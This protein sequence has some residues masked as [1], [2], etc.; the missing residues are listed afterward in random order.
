MAWLHV[1]GVREAAG[2]VDAVEVGRAEAQRARSRM[3]LADRRSPPWPG[4]GGRRPAGERDPRS[5]STRSRRR[6]RRSAPRRSS[7]RPRRSSARRSTRPDPQMPSGGTSPIVRKSKPPSRSRT[8]SMAPSAAGHPVADE[9]ALEG[10]AGRARRGQ[11]PLAVADE[12][13]SRVG[14]DVHE[15]ERPPRPTAVDRDEVGGGVRPDVAGDEGRAVDPSLGVDQQRR[16]RGARR[17]TAVDSPPAGPVSRARPWTGTG[18][19][20]IGPTSRPKKRSRIVELPTTTTS[21]TSRRSMPSSAQRRPEL[22]VEGTPER[23]PQLARA[24]PPRTRSG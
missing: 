22:V 4:R 1:D 23:P 14:A 9:A 3:P 8:D 17:A 13:T 6:H 11:E 5:G 10:R 18:R 20:P 2:E 21:R 16:A 12:T 7:S 19:R 24:A 15:Q